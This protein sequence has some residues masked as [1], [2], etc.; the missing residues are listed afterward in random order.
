[1]TNVHKIIERTENLEGHPQK[2]SQKWCFLYQSVQTVPVW[3]TEEEHMIRAYN[4][5]HN[6]EGK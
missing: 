6:L 2:T 5:V 1:M 3:I 4:T